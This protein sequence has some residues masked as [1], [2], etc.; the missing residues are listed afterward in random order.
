M[1]SGSK[2]RR[3]P[4]VSSDDRSDLG[5]ENGARVGLNSQWVIDV[6]RSGR[7]R[8][9]PLHSTSR[10][11]R[12]GAVPRSAAR[13]GSPKAAIMRRGTCYRARGAEPVREV[14]VNT[15]DGCALLT[16]STAQYPG[17]TILSMQYRGGGSIGDRTGKRPI[18]RCISGND[19]RT[20]GAGMSTWPSPGGLRDKIGR[21]VTINLRRAMPE[22]AAATRWA[23]FLAHAQTFSGS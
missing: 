3:F 9:G 11:Q 7:R 12:R 20:P 4:P 5:G 21:V 18:R 1:R 6:R 16:R 23:G 10:I 15:M 19:R 22:R 14:L 17:C 13:R 2:A 8:R